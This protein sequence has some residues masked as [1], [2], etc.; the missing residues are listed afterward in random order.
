MIFYSRFDIQTFRPLVERPLACYR[1][2][3]KIVVRLRYMSF[4]LDMLHNF[5]DVYRHEYCQ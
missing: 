1:M 2:M 5:P 4:F 3:G